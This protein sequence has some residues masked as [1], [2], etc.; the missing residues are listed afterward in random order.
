[1]AQIMF[2]AEVPPNDTSAVAA[3]SRSPEWLDFSS[4]ASRIVPPTGGGTKLLEGMW[5]LPADGTWPVVAGLAKHA[6]RCGIP[7][8]IFLIEG[9]VTEMSKP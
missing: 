7:F 3:P 5:L 9:A 2:I 4:V 8:K 1:M 6:E